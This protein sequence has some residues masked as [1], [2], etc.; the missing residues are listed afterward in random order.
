MGAT[1]KGTIFSIS[2]K[3]GN[4]EKS[5]CLGK[6]KGVGSNQSVKLKSMEGLNGG[7]G[8]EHGKYGTCSF[9]LPTKT[10][11]GGSKKGLKI[12][13]DGKRADTPCTLLGSWFGTKSKGHAEHRVVVNF[14]AVGTE[15]GSLDR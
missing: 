7:R 10:K 12:S 1:L 11:G 6:M 15:P 8:W 5:S 3:T 13:R 2:E 9:Q 14:R 4:G